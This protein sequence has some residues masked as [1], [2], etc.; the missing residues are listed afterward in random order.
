[1]DVDQF[2]YQQ[3]I[4]GDRQWSRSMLGYKPTDPK[5]FTTMPLTLAKAYGG[6]VSLENGDFSCLENPEGR[7][8][9]LKEMSPENVSLPNIERPDQLMREP[10]EQPKP[11]CMA[12]YPLTG[13]LRFDPLIIDGTVKEFDGSDSSLYF[14]QAHPDLMIDRPSPGTPVRLTGMSSGDAIQFETPPIPFEAYLVIDDTRLPMSSSMDG[15]CI[16]A[17]HNCV[18]FKFRAVARF[19]LEPRQTRCAVIKERVP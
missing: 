19:P 14:G 7:G 13:K 4:I 8:F 16:F 1:L 17:H 3:R 10:Y 12:P 11:T 2:T 5:P 15:I 18:G 6:K 9:L